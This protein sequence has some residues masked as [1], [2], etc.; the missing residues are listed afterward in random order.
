MTV[1]SECYA[2]MCGSAFLFITRDI[3]AG[4]LKLTVSE[5]ENDM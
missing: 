5:R 2:Y 1:Y 4:V 3:C